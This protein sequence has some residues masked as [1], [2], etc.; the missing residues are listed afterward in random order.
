[1]SLLIIKIFGKF[2]T[3]MIYIYILTYLDEA[4]S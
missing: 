3:R 1:M 4:K 2:Y